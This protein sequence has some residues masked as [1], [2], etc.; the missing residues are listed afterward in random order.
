[1][2]H[3]VAHGLEMI[4]GAIIFVLSMVFLLSNERILN[5]LITT[6][7]NSAVDD[8]DLYQQYS[9]PDKNLITSEEL[10][11]MVIGYREYP[12]MING[13]LID[14]NGTEY[15]NY[16]LLIKNGDYSRSYSYDL[17]RNIRSVNYTYNGT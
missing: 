1:M 9:N 12:I 3:N 15:E 17:E 13:F 14:S 5:R 4:I 10:Y 8:E 6:V 2:K 16:I 11:A 7:N